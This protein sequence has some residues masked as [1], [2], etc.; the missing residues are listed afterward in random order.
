MCI[1]V[2]LKLGCRNSVEPAKEFSALGYQVIE[3]V[4]NME[5]NEIGSNCGQMVRKYA[6]KTAEYEKAPA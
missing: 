2:V 1:P 3:S 6:G 4:G 5:E